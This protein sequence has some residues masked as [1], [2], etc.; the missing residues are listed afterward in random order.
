MSPV[1]E[2]H[3]YTAQQAVKILKRENEML[4]I[5]LKKSKVTGNK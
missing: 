1:E 3:C 5:A 2:D 4:K